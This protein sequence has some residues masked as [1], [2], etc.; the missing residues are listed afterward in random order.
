[1]NSRTRAPAHIHTQTKGL[2]GSMDQTLA[3][4]RLLL[5]NLIVDPSSIR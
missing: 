2:G 4:L 3:C 1:M 5:L